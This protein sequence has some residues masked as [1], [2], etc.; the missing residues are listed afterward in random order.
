MGLGHDKDSEELKKV[1]NVFLF[2]PVTR[3]QM[4]EAVNQILES[5]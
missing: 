3:K 4:V 1:V 5:R 2:K